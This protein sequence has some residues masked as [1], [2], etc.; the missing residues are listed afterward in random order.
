M[1][2]YLQN[3]LANVGKGLS[4][5]HFAQAVG[6]AGV[7]VFVLGFVNLFLPADPP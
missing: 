7:V 3:N 1:G 6:A 4:A 2:A 5:A